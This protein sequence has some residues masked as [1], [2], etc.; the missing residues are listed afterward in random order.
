MDEKDGGQRAPIVQL[1]EGD[2]LDIFSGLGYLAS[3]KHSGVRDYVIEKLE[4][5]P[6]SKIEFFLPQLCHLHSVIQGSDAEQLMTFIVANC[7][8][9]VHFC[10]KTLLT[11]QSAL[12]YAQTAE[13]RRRHMDLM[14][15]CETTFVN[16]QQLGTA[17][18]KKRAPSQPTGESGS[19]SKTIVR[20]RGAS[21][22]D[23]L[24]EN[25]FSFATPQRSSGQATAAKTT[26]AAS[27]SMSP[28]APAVK[29]A[30]AQDA[31]TTSGST[32]P[33]RKDRTAG[34]TLRAATTDETSR[35]PTAESPESESRTGSG[36]TENSASSRS[37]D[38]TKDT[39]NPASSFHP[40]S[41]A[42]KTPRPRP[43]TGVRKNMQL[44]RARSD[45]LNAE[46]Q[47]LKDLNQISEVL[48]KVRRKRRNQ[49]LHA[50][51]RKLN[52]KLPSGLYLP[53]RGVDERHYSVYRILYRQCR[54]LKSRDKAP[55][56]LVL[57]VLYTGKKCGERGIIECLNAIETET[58]N[59]SP[60]FFG[61]DRQLLNLIADE[62]RAEL[63]ASFSGEALTRHLAKNALRYA[64]KYKR[65]NEKKHSA[66]DLELLAKQF[67]NNLLA[68]GHIESC[69][70]SATTG[71]EED[72]GSLPDLGMAELIVKQATEYRVKG[73][74][75][76]EPNGA[77]SD[78]FGEVWSVRKEYLR[79]MSPVGSSS[80]W[81]LVSVIFKGGDDLRQEVL[82][83]QLIQICD[84]VFQSAGLPLQLRPYEVMV[85]SPD[86]GIIETIQDAI[87]IDSLKSDV[88]NFT[89]LA[90]FF[91]DYFGER[92]SPKHQQ[93]QRNFVESMAAYS[94]V[95]Y[96][97]AIKDRHNGNIMIDRE[98]R[99]IHIDFGFMLNNSPG[100][101]SNFESSPFK[102]TQEYVEVMEGEDSKAFAYFKLM[103]IRGLLELRKHVQKFEVAIKLMMEKSNM[104]CFAP[105]SVEDLKTRLALGMD[106]RR[107]VEFAIG[108]VEESINNW[109][110][111][112]YDEYQRITNGIR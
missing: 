80:N 15:N 108:L 2:G 53:G 20:T 63:P 72:L 54:S 85:T 6:L 44:K 70:S 32:P 93:A 3:T 69:K 104:A 87:S 107:C 40:G 37:A 82:A 66:T 96:L 27:D 92:G 56:L 16:V 77:G 10:L 43:S 64:R 48:V 26:A 81:D 34:V 71:A 109:R 97:L 5:T 1:E 101:N 94:L 13:Q 65:T 17:V 105:T 98:G 46:L 83:M 49:C 61:Q 21:L 11:L 106:E 14:H 9:S 35:A 4:E 74:K 59:N 41:V 99:I 39:S 30:S 79:K 33:A 67:G 25:H 23:C 62:L 86:S 78:P 60:K 51:L 68:A 42:T 55:Y 47:F 22:E 7:S 102:L 111:V 58:A 19:Q 89:S 12:D 91:E 31:T 18:R 100:G 24:R 28:A 29:Q 90:D 73:R 110:S 95:T 84:D 45:Y 50:C 76:A 112:Q 75:T 52:S 103:F 8:E 36:K 38:E 88:P 57:E